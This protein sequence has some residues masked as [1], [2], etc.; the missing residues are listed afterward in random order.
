MSGINGH[1]VC[2]ILIGQGI[3]QILMG[4]DVCQILMGCGVYQILMVRG[5]C[6]LFIGVE[7]IRYQWGVAYS[8]KGFNQIMSLTAWNKLWTIKY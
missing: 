8:I 7:Y 6:Q 2:Q 1:G 4:L 3:C 5:T